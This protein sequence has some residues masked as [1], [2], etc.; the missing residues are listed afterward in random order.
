MTGH[1][2]DRKQTLRIIPITN[3]RITD[4]RTES[5]ECRSGYRG[6][7]HRKYRVFSLGLGSA[8]LTCACGF[9][10]TRKRLMCLRIIKEMSCIGCIYVDKTMENVTAEML[11]PHFLCVCNDSSCYL[12][13]LF[14]YVFLISTGKEVDSRAHQSA[15]CRRI[16]RSQ[17]ASALLSSSSEESSPQHGP[18]PRS[19]VEGS[20]FTG[21]CEV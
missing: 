8:F 7:N 10:S 12:D 9:V 16:Y 18:D 1:H 17:V 15:Y 2:N 6:T 20:R 13:S 14:F 4:P 5:T 3:T 11:R 19:A 21:D